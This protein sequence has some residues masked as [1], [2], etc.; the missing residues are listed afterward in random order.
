MS[1]NTKT[2]ME[3][4]L[5]GEI[6]WANDPEILKARDLGY[7]NC[8]E[9]NNTSPSEVDKRNNIIKKLFKKIGDNFCLVPRINV[10]YGF[11][12]SAGNNFYSN[13]N[14]VILDEAE[15]TFGD[16][17]F[18][19]PNCSFYTACHP[20][21]YEQRN[22]CYEYAKKIIVGNNVWIGGNVVVCPGVTIGDGA[23]IGAGSVV[24]RDIPAN[25]VAFGN[26]CKARRE[27]TEKDKINNIEDILKK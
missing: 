16:N 15:V 11:N 3:K 13:Y 20:I 19:G 22:A 18:V 12:I 7:I 5:S 6:Y 27:I 17:V 26:P 1:Q 23:V 2:N 4:M 14:L 25:M 9:Y 10:D 24:T 8:M 21:D